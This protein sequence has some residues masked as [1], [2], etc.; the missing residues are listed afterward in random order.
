[1]NERKQINCNLKII[2]YKALI[3]LLQFCFAR[4][5][6]AQITPDNTLGN[7]PSIVKQNL[8]NLTIEGGVRNNSNIFHSFQE[9]NVNNGQ[10]VY[11]KSFQDINNII[12][13][14][15]GNN[16]SNIKGVLGVN[17]AANL[18]LINPNGIIFGK[19]SSL[20]IKG[21]FIG[22]TAESINFSDG[23]IFSAVEPNN[24][25]LLEINVPLGLQY[26][27]N[28]API[29]LNQ[30]DLKIKPKQVLGLIGGN[31]NSDNSSLTAP[32]GTV[33]LAG[34][35]STGTVNLNDLNS[36][37]F[38][39]DT[40]FHDISIVNNSS[41]NVAAAD[42]GN[43]FI[44]ANNFS[45]NDSNFRAG[46][47]QGLGNSNAVSGDIRINATGNTTIEQSNINNILGANS[48]GN[49]GEI[50]IK[51]NNLFLKDSKILTNTYSSGNVG[52]LIVEA[53]NKVEIIS[54][55]SNFNL[56]GAE[57]RKGLFSKVELN[58]T[59]N[60]GDIIVSAK[61][62]LVSG[63]GGIDI[64]TGGLGNAGRVI[65]NGDRLR[66]IEGAGVYSNT[67]SSGNAGEISIEAS[68]F[69]EVSNKISDAEFAD[70]KR[71]PGGIIADVRRD[72]AGNGGKI[73][74][75]TASLT[76]KEGAFLTTDTKGSGEGGDINI[77]ARDKVE[78][79]GN[80]EGITTQLVTA[81][82]EKATGSGGNLTI[83]TKDLIV[84]DGAEINAGTD[85]S[86]NSGN[87]NIKASESIQL[88]GTANGVPSRLLAQVGDKGSGNGGN[89]LLETQ[90]LIIRDGSQISAG[91]LGN[92][93]GGNINV[94][95]G[96]AVN[97]EGF[98]VI[99]SDKKNTEIVTDE[100]GTLY[101]S[102]IFSSSPGIGDAGN[103]NIETAN[104][105]ISNNAQVSVSSQLEGA[106][107]NLSI[108]ATK[109]ALFDKGILNA[110]TVAGNQANIN[111]NSPN[112]QLRYGSRIT[113]NAT[114]TATGG[115]INIDTLTLVAL[116]NSDITA[117]AEESFGGKISINAQGIFGTQFRE[118]LTPE[119]DIT[120]SS[121]LGAEFSGAVE[122]DTIGTDPNSG[123]VQLPT[124]LADSSQKIAS[125]CGKNQTGK[126]TVAGRGGLPESPNEMFAVNNPMVDLVD[127]V[128]NSA[129]QNISV[130]SKSSINTKKEIVEAQGWVVD[131]EGNVEF[132]AEVPEAVANSGGISQA[133]CQS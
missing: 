87:V 116:E 114:Q 15:T 58:A 61:D 68:D 6:S 50:Y 13:R 57:A 20:D 111:L 33:E 31:I 113:T 27:N 83:E 118:F 46:I 9:F 128:S 66:I 102:G 131:A 38:S 109:K 94:L 17:G 55:P 78:I 106:A 45:L 69:I 79:I 10:Q 1:M 120:A 18:F 105:N 124:G 76:V 53:D 95:V 54:S 77:F 42:N 112:I 23:S 48:S 7:S 51:T 132:V 35:S 43:I 36:L 100:T 44:N 119:S 65:I 90:E 39:E 107:G 37:S 25:A 93:K 8:N 60:T 41:I 63:L 99:N 92:G 98:S 30:A 84:R 62:I 110:D 117:N 11:F 21:S 104:F 12:T 82:R 56:K 86:S 91:N 14:V 130:S 64:S 52:D 97:I 101:P 81:V 3:G 47:K 59:G 85:S 4:S 129:N 72:A 22:A 26:G 19:G 34:L 24:P 5:A 122:I 125:G 126:F 80:Q 67:N 16:T 71:Q 127:V 49:G 29:T 40:N 96:D 88:F 2:S 123:L 89:I 108:L 74:I 121:E 133:Y 32:G 28:P 70:I 73:S 103:L 115:N 75:E